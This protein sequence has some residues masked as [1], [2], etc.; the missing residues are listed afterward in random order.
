M[1][2]K[3]K[4]SPI[5]GVTIAEQIFGTGNPVPDTT[6]TSASQSLIESAGQFVTP[7]EPLDLDYGGE[8]DI[9]IPVDLSAKEGEVDPEKAEKRAEKRAKRKKKI[10]DVKTKIRDFLKKKKGPGPGPGSGDGDDDAA[11]GGDASGGDAPGSEYQI[12]TEEE[13]RRQAEIDALNKELEEDKRKEREEKEKK[14]QEEALEQDIDEDPE[15]DDQDDIPK[16]PPPRPEVKIEPVPSIEIQE[17]EIKTPESSLG[18]VTPIPLP[19]GGEKPPPPLAHEDP[20]KNPE[21]KMEGKVVRTGSNKLKVEGDDGKVYEI[22]SDGPGYIYHQGTDEWYYTN[23]NGDITHVQ[24][25][26]VPEGHLI[27]HS[28][29]QQREHNKQK[30]IDREYRKIKFNPKKRREFLRKNP[31]FVPPNKR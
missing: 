6:A 26:Q 14:K 8:M 19:S 23:K 3:M 22:K 5:K 12:S 31:D 1:A 9:K 25:E 24:M 30:A 10:A 15:E 17:I 28:Q 4:R 21:Y 29:E 13:R 2:F 11:G 20:K 18:L 27:L 7:V 16:P